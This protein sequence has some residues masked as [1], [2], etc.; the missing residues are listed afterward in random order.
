VNESDRNAR[1][2]SLLVSVGTDFHPFDRLVSWVDEWLTQQTDPHE[3]IVQ[4]GT[5]RPP[6]R[7]EG[8]AFVTHEELG[9]LMTRARVV[10]CH[11]G[12]STIAEAR[13]R[14]HLPIVVPRSPAH[15]EHVD[16]H[17]QRFSHRLARQGL[18]RVATSP[19]ELAA[20]IAETHRRPTS[21]AG[22]DEPLV[23]SEAARR[24][25]E[26]VEALLSSRRR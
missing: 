25:G 22:A 1:P 9:A 20:A 21:H 17:Q 7:A 24:F 26:L 5:S 16:D 3:C 4:Y 19:A 15:G 18:V 6:R 11:G 14:G 8:V 23:G 12:P 10:V 13:R 2:L